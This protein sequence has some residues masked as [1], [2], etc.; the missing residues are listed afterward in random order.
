MLAQDLNSQH[1]SRGPIWLRLLSI[2]SLR[3]R[4]PRQGKERRAGCETRAVC[5]CVSRVSA[6]CNEE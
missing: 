6:C 2:L 5:V 4:R 3:R 1:G